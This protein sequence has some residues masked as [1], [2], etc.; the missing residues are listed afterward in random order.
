MGRCRSILPTC[1]PQKVSLAEGVSVN[2]QVGQHHDSPSAAKCFRVVLRGFR[3]IP[4]S[5][6]LGT[7]AA[8]RERGGGT[9]RGRREVGLAGCAGPG[10]DGRKG[11]GREGHDFAVHLSRGPL[12]RDGQIQKRLFDRRG[13]AVVRQRRGW[14]N[15]TE[16]RSDGCVRGTTPLGPRKRPGP[17]TAPFMSW[18]CLFCPP[19]SL[20]AAPR[21]APSG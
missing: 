4:L 14:P 5:A 8:N 21:L 10:H 7:V 19:C 2:G 16:Q 1:S 20:Q 3:A 17:A 12:Q 18:V 11:G 15:D 9:T 13:P 6:A